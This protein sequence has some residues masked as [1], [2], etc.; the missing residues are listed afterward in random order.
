M[1]LSDSI[2][3]V[4]ALSDLVSQDREIPSLVYTEIRVKVRYSLISR[5]ATPR[6]HVNSAFKSINEISNPPEKHFLLY[7]YQR[8]KL[9]KVC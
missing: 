8:H 9:L 7:S 1:N 4:L 6:S 2:P 3:V 5:Y